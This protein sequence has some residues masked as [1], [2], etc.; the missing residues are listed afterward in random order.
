MDEPLAD[1]RANKPDFISLATFK[2][3]KTISLEVKKWDVEKTHEAIRKKMTIM[4]KEQEAPLLFA[5]LDLPG[6]FKMA[7]TIPYQF[8][9]LFEDSTE[10]R[11]S[12]MVEDWEMFSLFRKY[13]QSNEDNYQNAVEQVK[14]TYLK[15]CANKD[16]FFFLG[17][18]LNDQGG[19]GLTPIPS[20]ASSIRHTSRNR[21]LDFDRKNISHSSSRHSQTIRN[22]L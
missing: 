10:K 13:Y 7:G 4:D 9:H 12:L 11:C 1:S 22:H 19:I 14:T 18:R 2:P 16:L 17:T 6:Y 21:P 5:E 15:K 20:S 8:N 3:S